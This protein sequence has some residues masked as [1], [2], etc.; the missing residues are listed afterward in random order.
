MNKKKQKP[1]PSKADRIA[2]AAAQDYAHASTDSI[3]RR[4]TVLACAAS[5]LEDEIESLKMR[6]AAARG[7][8]ARAEAQM[9]G[10]ASV[11]SRR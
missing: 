4:R 10:L 11:V 8:L 7:E 5:V 2:G 3:T 1:R 9:A 6:L